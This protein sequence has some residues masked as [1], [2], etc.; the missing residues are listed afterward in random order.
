LKPGVTT[1]DAPADV[2]VQAGRD[3]VL[4]RDHLAAQHLADQAPA[5]G[6]HVLE[7]PGQ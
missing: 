1:K 6:G 5:A 2:D 4:G 7:Q 3:G